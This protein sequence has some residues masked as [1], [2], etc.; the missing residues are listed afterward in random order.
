MRK[1]WKCWLSGRSPLNFIARSYVAQQVFISQSTTSIFTL[2]SFIHCSAKVPL[3]LNLLFN[4]F[5]GRYWREYFPLCQPVYHSEYQFH[6]FLL[7]MKIF[8]Y[9][10]G[11]H[12]SIFKMAQWV[13]KPV[14]HCSFKQKIFRLELKLCWSV[15]I[16]S[17]RFGSLA[18]HGS[19]TVFV[20]LTQCNIVATLLCF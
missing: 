10:S 13:P 12:V 18:I 5:F 15:T 11:I 19:M 1:L 6:L 16:F 14:R 4:N 2:V 9:R 7:K 3:F 20:G 8:I 17:C